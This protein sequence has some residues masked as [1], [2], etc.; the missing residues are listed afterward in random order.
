MAASFPNRMAAQLCTLFSSSLSDVYWAMLWH[1]HSY[2]SR[3]TQ[4]CI[5]TH[6]SQPPSRPM[7]L[8]MCENT[9]RIS[10]CL[11]ARLLSLQTDR[12]LATN[13]WS[14]NCQCV[15]GGL[16]H[17]QELA[18]EDGPDAATQELCLYSFT[19]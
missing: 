15:L 4:A 9:A 3:H 17:L 16:E 13:P 1:A 2:R 14:I 18:L 5:V 6:A 10:H 7:W 8:S 19:K 11:L 12:F